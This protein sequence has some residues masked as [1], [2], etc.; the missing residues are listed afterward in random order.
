MWFLVFRS[1]L[2]IFWGGHVTWPC[3]TSRRT[4]VWCWRQASVRSVLVQSWASWRWGP[5]S[6]QA[7]K[8][9]RQH[10]PGN[11]ERSWNYRANWL[12]VHPIHSV[13]MPR[14]GWLSWHPLTSVISTR[15]LTFIAGRF[16]ERWDYLHRN[17]LSLPGSHCWA[18]WAALESLDAAVISTI[19][20]K[21]V[22]HLFI[23]HV[24]P[25]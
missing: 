4:P 12:W 18:R 17:Q 6:Q 7:L 15:I 3:T 5:A 16:R 20:R 11:L 22:L 10:G 1:C 19:Y 2:T 24:S 9:V 14:Q 25:T 21:K 8:Q 23:I 13:P